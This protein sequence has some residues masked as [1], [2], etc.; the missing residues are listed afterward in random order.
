M[1]IKRPPVYAW[2]WCRWERHV[3]QVLLDGFKG[4]ATSPFV[5]GVVRG[6]PKAP[7]SS[8]KTATRFDDVKGWN[9][10]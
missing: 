4:R 5:V 2:V 3:S 8:G 6:A 10:L 9:G 7:I 1:A